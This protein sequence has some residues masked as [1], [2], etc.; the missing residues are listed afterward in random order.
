MDGIG[1]NLKRIRLLKKCP[2]T[3]I[4]KIDINNLIDELEKDSVT[5]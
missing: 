2:T 3:R 4:P 1:K 5:I